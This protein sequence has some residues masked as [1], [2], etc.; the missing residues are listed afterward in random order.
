MALEYEAGNDQFEIKVPC[1]PEYVRTV[2]RAIADF[3]ESSN[4]PKATV[5]EIE[6]AASEAVTNIVR[7]AYPDRNCARP[8]RVKCVRRK[9]GFTVEIADRGCGFDAS[10]NG[11]IAD[12]DLD[13]DGGFGILLIKTLMDSVNFVSK[14]QE[15][16]KI[17]MTKRAKQALSK[18][19][20]EST[21]SRRKRAS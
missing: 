10:S 6:I 16:T 4:V 8:V 7:H 17:R 20:R 9:N 12:L 11:V 18:A 5:A 15:G 2:R 19:A 1:R 14:P 21:S 13:R 3:A